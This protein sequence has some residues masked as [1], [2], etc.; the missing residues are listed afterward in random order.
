MLVILSD[1]TNRSK[2]RHLAPPPS[3]SLTLFAPVSSPLLSVY[4][5]L[6]SLLFPLLSW[7][8]LGGSATEY[9]TV[10][11]MHQVLKSCDCVIGREEAGESGLGGASIIC[12]GMSLGREK[13]FVRH[14]KGSQTFGVSDGAA[15]NIAAC[16]SVTCGHV[17]ERVS[18]GEEQGKKNT[19]SRWLWADPRFQQRLDMR[20]YN[21]TSVCPAASVPW[22]VSPQASGAAAMCVSAQNWLDWVPVWVGNCQ[23][24]THHGT[25]AF[26]GWNYSVAVFVFVFSSLGTMHNIYLFFLTRKMKEDWNMIE[27]WYLWRLIYARIIRSAP[28]AQ[29]LS[30]SYSAMGCHHKVLQLNRA[31]TFGLK[32]CDAGLLTV[33]TCDSLT[34]H[35]H[36]NSQLCMPIHYDYVPVLMVKNMPVNHFAN[37]AKHQAS[38]ITQDI[39][40]TAVIAC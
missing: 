28:P 32:R 17:V 25:I 35:R 21:S 5:A 34:H 10:A 39:A 13:T 20:V 26:N 27:V 19:N 11:R 1:M 18:V 29:L 31:R 37:A 6:L 4:T 30:W 36:T 33:F 7:G 23:V 22:L 38:V 40:K 24:L 8:F 15:V 2:P 12:R 16:V 3:L 9:W 14:L